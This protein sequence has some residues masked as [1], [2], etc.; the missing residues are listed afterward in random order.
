MVTQPRAARKR[1]ERMRRIIRRARSLASHLDDPIFTPVL[2]S[3]ARVS[4]LLGDCYEKLRDGN[5]IGDNGELRP[6]IDIIR[7]LAETQARLARELG[8]TPATLRS[9]SREKNVDLASAFAEHVDG[10]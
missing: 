7:K 5:L 8:L 9:M 6:S 10:E 1:D 3:F 2:Q 4:L